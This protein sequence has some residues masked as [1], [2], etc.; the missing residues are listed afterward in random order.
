MPSQIVTP[1]PAGEGL[2]WRSTDAQGWPLLPPTLLTLHRTS[3]RDEGSRQVVCRLDGVRLADLLFG[4]Q[5]TMEVLP[6]EHELRVHNTLMW[7]TLRFTVA[8]G[9]HA[10]FGVVNRAPIGFYVLLLTIGVAP[11]VLEVER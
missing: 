9:G 4:Q 7:R 3:P 8:P 2:E 1:R 10:R 11:L 6:G 5:F